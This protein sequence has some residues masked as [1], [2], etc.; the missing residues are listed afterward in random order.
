MRTL[1]VALLVS[2][3][4]CN[5]AFG[6]DRTKPWD[7][8]PDSPPVDGGEVKLSLTWQ[9]MD[10]QGSGATITTPPI[11][12]VAVQVGAFDGMLQNA[13][14]DA[15]GNFHVLEALTANP[16]RIVYTVPGD[17]V[18]HEVQW[19]GGA[20]AHLVVPVWGRLPHVAPPANKWF[21]FHVTNPPAV[22]T[23]TNQATVFTRGQWS[24]GTTFA[25]AAKVTYNYWQ[26]MVAL[27]GAPATPDAAHSDEEVLAQFGT[28]TGV[29]KLTGFARM[30]ADLTD[31][32]ALGTNVNWQT[33][34]DDS[35]GYS[36]TA[37]PQTRIVSSVNSEP[38]PTINSVAGVIPSTNMPVMTEP[39]AAHIAGTGGMFQLASAPGQT[40]PLPFVNPFAPS[41]T[42][43]PMVDVI[44][45]QLVRERTLSSLPLDSGFVEIGTTGA[46]SFGFGVG[47]ATAP[48][49]ATVP[50]SQLSSEPVSV[51]V[52]A[53][54]FADLSFT[55]DT[56]ATSDCTI[57]LYQ[58]SSMLTPLRTF[59]VPPGN[60]T[61]VHVPTSALQDGGEYVF[62]IACTDQH[63]IATPMD[64]SQL[65]PYPRT[66]S[67]LAPAAFTVSIH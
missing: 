27:G 38:A 35:I 16:Y 5:Q 41:A 59:L 32:S 14:V 64:F 30:S 62:T 25:T 10:G 26:N 22:F 60:P 61:V 63:A 12:G 19:Q 65:N 4:G 56:G 44:E 49:F 34:S 58:V 2:A 51:P 6:L 66:T 48:T 39:D 37:D 43:S 47:I 3:A 7:A 29:L 1:V 67:Q 20:G 54:S 28:V 13:L 21:V 33:P 53:N 18:V 9:L 40:Q 36:T 42:S 52:M 17:P 23:G 31:L 24:T 57:T 45:E 11:D 15:S 55:L 46:S 50:L 8:A